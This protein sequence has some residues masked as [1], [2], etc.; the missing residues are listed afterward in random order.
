M[1]GVSA[2]QKKV[3]M[4]TRLLE[5]VAGAASYEPVYQAGDAPTKPAGAAIPKII[6][7]AVVYVW[8]LHV[9]KRYVCASGSPS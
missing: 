5:I 6:V 3:D 2:V 7:Q 9:H 8:G 1:G 4:G